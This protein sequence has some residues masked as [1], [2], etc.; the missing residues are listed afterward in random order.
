MAGSSNLSKEVMC[1]MGCLGGAREFL[2][3]RII[4]FVFELCLVK[5]GTPQYFAFSDATVSFS[6]KGKNNLSCHVNQSITFQ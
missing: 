2:K 6:K 1:P 3:M 4:S 5:E